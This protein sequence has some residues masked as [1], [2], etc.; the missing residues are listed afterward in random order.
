MVVYTCSVK[1][2][3]SWGRKINW[4]QKFKISLI[5]FQKLRACALGTLSPYLTASSSLNRRG[6][7]SVMVSWFTAGWPFSREKWRGK[8][9]R[10][11]GAGREGKVCPDVK[12]RKEKKIK[13][14]GQQDSSVGKG[15]RHASLAA[16]LEH[17][18]VGQLFKDV[19]WLWHVHCDTWTHITYEHTQTW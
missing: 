3:G 15:A 4:A 16:A 2:L 5:P 12:T 17:I 8:S 1:Y 18:N 10:C 14:L 13:G 11:E 6:G 7:T 9:G 19:L